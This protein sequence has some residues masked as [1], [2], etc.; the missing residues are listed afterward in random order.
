MLLDLK[1]SGA[2]KAVARAAF[3]KAYKQEIGV[4]VAEVRKRIDNIS[5]PKDIWRVHDYLSAKRRQTDEK[6]DYRYSV[7]PMVFAKLIHEKWLTEADL[8]GLG[9]DKLKVIRT[10]LA[11]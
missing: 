1:W 2:E 9:E 11:L 4:I 5:D 7:L 6:Y 8:N 10:I 3:E